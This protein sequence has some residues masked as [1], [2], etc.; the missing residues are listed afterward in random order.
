MMPRLRDLKKEVFKILLLD[1]QNKLIDDPV[2]VDEGTVT[3]ATPPIREIIS[4]ALQDSAAAIVAVHNHPSG[5]PQ[6]SEGDKEFTRSLV[7]A[8]ETM[9]VKVLD[10]I[11][12]GDNK[13]YSFADEGLL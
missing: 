5:D 10:H 12:I 7:S 9:Q 6:P 11:I 1:G 4:R 3:Q 13:Y 2:E 8:G